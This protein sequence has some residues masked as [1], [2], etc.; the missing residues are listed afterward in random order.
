MPHV[1]DLNDIRR[2]REDDVRNKPATVMSETDSE[3]PRRTAHLI[4]GDTREAVQAKIAWLV[5]EVESFGAGG[6]GEFD[7]PTRFKGF[8]YAIGQTVKFEDINL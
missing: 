5:A 6:Y 7:G 2:Q 8:Y 4:V 1:I 3:C